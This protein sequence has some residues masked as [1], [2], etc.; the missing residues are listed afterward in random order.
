M[1]DVDDVHHCDVEY[2]HDCDVRFRDIEWDGRVRWLETVQCRQQ[3]LVYLDIYYNRVFL[4]TFF[5]SSQ[6]VI[7]LTAVI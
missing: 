7:I 3:V 6:P 2:V 1:T 4:Y 5:S